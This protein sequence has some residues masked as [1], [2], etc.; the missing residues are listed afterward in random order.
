MNFKS[1]LVLSVVMMLSSLSAQAQT[2]IDTTTSWDGTS[3]VSAFG[4]PN[5]ATYGQTIRVTS[6]SQ[7]N[8]FNFRLKG[9]GATVTLRGHVFAWDGT[10][11][12]GTSLYSSPAQALPSSASFQTVTFSPSVSLPS[13]DY[14]L[15]ISTSEDQTGAPN[16]GCQLGFLNNDTAYADGSFVYINNGANASQWTTSGWSIWSADTAFV[17]NFTSAAPAAIPTLSEWAM[18]FMASLMAMFGIRRMRRNK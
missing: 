11:A 6:A 2:N 12:T 4:V 7:L 8:D 13:G 16:S 5:T 15:F 14:V 18:I 3:F 1:W 10:K 17:V 9:C